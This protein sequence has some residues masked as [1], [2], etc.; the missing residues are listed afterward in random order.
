MEEFPASKV[1]LYNLQPDLL[2]NFPA[3]ACPDITSGPTT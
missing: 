1:H 3:D 2:G